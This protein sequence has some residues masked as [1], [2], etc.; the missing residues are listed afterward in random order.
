MIEIAYA[1][2]WYIVF[3]ISATI[4][5]AAH[6]WVAKIGG[7]LT[8][9][10]GGQVS[11]NPYPHMRR[12]I[13]GMVILPIVSAIGI[14]WPFGYATT[15]YDQ[16]WAYN[17][18]R[19]AAWMAVAGPA[20]NLLIVIICYIVIQLGIISGFLLQPDSIGFRHIV[21]T[22]LEGGWSG[23]AL[24]TSMM[25]T[26]NLIMF[27]LNLIPLPPLD[28]SA[29]ISLF[30]HVNSARSYRKFISNPLFSLA[31]LA[32]AWFAFSP[33]F[34]VVFLGTINIVYWG[35]GYH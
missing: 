11:L 1:F 3:I 29:V 9:Y 34:H 32:I 30:L 21:D 6:A 12:E 24:F 33:L 14:G 28:G 20:S 35:S 13:F 10:S 22:S 4:H 2:L 18:P 26:M 15:P 31:G 19:K 8:A 16:N 23:I 7:D 27:V 5:E 25:F 17:H